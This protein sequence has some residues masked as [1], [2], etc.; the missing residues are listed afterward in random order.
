MIDNFEGKVNDFNSFISFLSAL[1]KMIAD[2]FGANCEV[3]ISNLDNT[4]HSVL[5]IYNGD[6][7]GRRVGSPLNPETRKRLKNGDGGISVN[8]RKNIKFNKKAIKSSTIVINAFGHNISFCINV[9]CSDLE[10]IS[11]MLN[12]FLY[13]DEDKYDL[14]EKDQNLQ[15]NIIE[16]VENEVRKLDKSNKTLT[17]A[18]RCK[19][20]SNLQDAGIFNL[21]K[22]AVLVA[23]ALG[24]SRYTVYNYLKEI[25]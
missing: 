22:S 11:S 25:E 1:A 15:P 8:Y 5:A 4:E 6:I 20:I 17:K 24:V 18:D 3:A 7:T 23:E 10:T 19:I 13:M 16:V 21:R 9:D 14:I 12:S 2:S